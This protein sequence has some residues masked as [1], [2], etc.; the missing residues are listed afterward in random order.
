MT[1]YDTIC[2]PCGHTQTERHSQLT[3]DLMSVSLQIRSDKNQDQTGV[4][5][6]AL[7]LLSTYTGCKSEGRL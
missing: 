2:C 1:D 4:A 6:A 3:N 7:D 5:T